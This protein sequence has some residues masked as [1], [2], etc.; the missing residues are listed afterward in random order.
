[1]NF[2]N[3]KR[4]TIF[5]VLVFALVPVAE[6]GDGY[7]GGEK[8]LELLDVYLGLRAEQPAPDEFN[9]SAMADELIDGAIP[10][11]SSLTMDDILEAM[12]RPEVFDSSTSWTD[13]VKLVGK[14]LAANPGLNIKDLV[15]LKQAVD[16][17]KEADA[18]RKNVSNPAREK[19]Y[20]EGVYNELVEEQTGPDERTKYAMADELIKSAIPV[21]GVNQWN[22]IKWVDILQATRDL[23]EM[24]DSGNLYG[25]TNWTDCVKL[26]GKALATNSKLNLKDPVA[27]KQAIEAEIVK[28][29]PVSAAT[30][31]TIGANITISQDDQA[32]NVLQNLAAE[33]P[34]SNIS[35]K[36]AA[37]INLIDAVIPAERPDQNNLFVEILL[38][39]DNPDLFG[40][41][42][43]GASWTDAV[44]IVG[45]AL[46]TN[47]NLD[48]KDL[49]ATK[50]AI[51]AEIAKAAIV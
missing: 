51:E 42:G 34:G 9:R 23:E 37:A 4:I 25:V 16:L 41:G 50:Q 20:L 3:I 15:A 5:W 47:P 31:G 7:L 33:Q 48:L 35:I 27:L 32:D 10:A 12:S 30:L 17:A 44:I 45:K 14:A 19:F 22:P 46:A 49:V 21:V 8:D 40:T 28:Q 18:R 24:A 13:N 2:F 36:E 26:V 6:G 1:M 43:V 39:I 38:T 11:G 29:A